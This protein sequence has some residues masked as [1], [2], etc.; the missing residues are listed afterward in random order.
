LPKTFEAKF[1]W[2]DNAGRIMRLKTR[3]W[4]LIMR[5][6]KASLQTITQTLLVPH[7]S[8]VSEITAVNPVIGSLNAVTSSPAISA[9]KRGHIEASCF[10]KKKADEGKANNAEEQKANIAQ[11]DNYSEDYAHMAQDNI[12]KDP[13][14]LIDSGANSHFVANKIA[15][16]TYRTVPNAI[17]EGVAGS[18]AIVGRGDVPV[19]FIS[20]EGTRTNVLL[21]DCAHV[22]SFT[23]NLL[24]VRRLD[25]S[26]V[27]IHIHNG[28]AR[29]V[30]PNSSFVFGYGE[31]TGKGLYSIQIITQNELDYHTAFQASVTAKTRTW[32][33]LHCILGHA[34]QRAVE[35]VVKENP[36]EFVIDN[37]S[38]KDYVCEACIEGKL[39]VTSFPQ[40]S[41]TKYTE[42][43]ELVVTDIW[44]KAQTRALQGSEYFVVFI[45]VYL[46]L[47]RIYF[48]K[49]NKEVRERF[50]DYKAFVHNQT[51][52]TI[53]RLRSDNGSEY[54][55]K[56]LRG[57]AESKGIFFE[58]TAPHSSS[59]NRI[60]ERFNRAIMNL[61]RTGLRKHSLPNYLWQEGA[62]DMTYVRK[63]LPTR[64]TGRTPYKMFYKKKAPLKHMEEFG[65]EI[66]VL[67]QSGKN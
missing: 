56:E 59:Q 32:E 13:D 40:K 23:S 44:G 29:L 47:V 46:R 24:S 42:V 14:W 33:Q 28:W 45:D 60:A 43:G 34:H 18:T 62:A 12:G 20:P 11:E 9:K 61:V 55:N 21:R 65:A 50:E 54:I 57:Y 49:S 4:L 10:K 8:L 48:L 1:W 27:K 64:A 66:W 39:H 22:P 3:R 41:E 51:G 37:N 25:K 26:G 67:D 52:K 63:R 7:E 35:K 38:L 53:K 15:F 30:Y 17:V 2:K 36:T 31:H 19:V 6:N 5:S 58:Q 16:S